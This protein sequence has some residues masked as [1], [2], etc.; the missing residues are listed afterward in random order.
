MTT[1]QKPQRGQPPAA[2]PAPQLETLTKA[3]VLIRTALTWISLSGAVVGVF[4]I[5]KALGEQRS[6]TMPALLVGACFLIVTAAQQPWPYQLLYQWRSE[7]RTRRINQR[8]AEQAAEQQATV[9]QQRNHVDDDVAPLYVEPS[10]VL[11]ED[12][13]FIV[14]T[15]RDLMDAGN[16]HQLAALN[17]FWQDIN[18]DDALPDNEHHEYRTAVDQVYELVEDHDLYDDSMSDAELDRQVTDG[19]ANPTNPFVFVYELN[20][21]S[22]AAG[23]VAALMLVRTQV[24]PAVYDAIMD[25]WCE[26]GLPF[27]L[28]EF[29][30][31]VAAGGDGYHARD[32]SAPNRRGAPHRRASTRA[33]TKPPV[34]DIDEVLADAAEKRKQAEA[35]QTAEAPPAQAAPEP[36][37]P[38]ADA[39]E[40]PPVKHVEPARDDVPNPTLDQVLQATELLTLSNFGSIPMLQRKMRIGFALATKI[41]YQLERT[42]GVVGPRPDGDGAREVLVEPGEDL[43]ATL[44]FI[45]ENWTD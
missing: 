14:H 41:M 12:F 39:A 23:A 43:E 44:S 36:D 40:E 20:T 1:T 26:V 19:T 38:A 7:V 4:L 13:A 31:E 25:P 33:V 21:H 2:A 16:V 15:V 34:A 3:M 24:P 32:V 17:Q 11:G 29:V 37:R 45:R 42:F 9:P 8:R 30:W 5:A 27:R 6:W 18:W 35:Q 28:A 22:P 10:P